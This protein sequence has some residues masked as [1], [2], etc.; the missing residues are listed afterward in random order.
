MM[1]RK[2]A[3]PGAKEG[4]TE[5]RQ[6]AF[7]LRKQGKS[8]LAI[9][10]ELG[11]SDAQAHRDVAQ[12]LAAITKLTGDRAEEWRTLEIERLDVA[13]AAIWQG[14]KNGDLKSIEQSLKIMERRAK[15]LGLDAPVKEEHSGG[16]K[17]T[18][19]YADP[20]TTD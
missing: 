20:L 15:L 7:E 14:V 13:Y 19:A 8:F 4:A 1:S 17:V 11:I 6:K 10:K 5:R 3:N 9:G 12:V 18:V 2:D 16:I